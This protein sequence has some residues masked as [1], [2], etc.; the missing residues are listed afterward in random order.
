M[1]R[2]GVRENNCVLIERARKIFRQIW[3]GRHHTKYMLID[4]FGLCDRFLMPPEILNC[5]NK[6]ESFSR[7]GRIDAHQ[8]LD[9]ILE[10]YNRN[11]KNHISGVANSIKWETVTKNYDTL[12]ILTGNINSLLG[13]IEHTR[14]PRQIQEFKSER[15]IFRAELRKTK[16]L[17]PINERNIIGKTKPCIL[18][19]LDPFPDKILVV[20]SE[21]LCQNEIVKYAMECVLLF[22]INIYGNASK[23]FDHVITF[24]TTGSISKENDLFPLLKTSIIYNNS[25]ASINDLVSKIRLKIMPFCNILAK[26]GITGTLSL[27][28]LSFKH[29]ESQIFGLIISTGKL[30]L[31]I[32]L[33]EY[34]RYRQKHQ[35]HKTVD[36]LGQKHVLRSPNTKVLIIMDNNSNRFKEAVSDISDICSSLICFTSKPVYL[37]CSVAGKYGSAEENCLRDIYPNAWYGCTRKK[38]IDIAQPRFEKYSSVRERKNSFP[39]DWIKNDQDQVKKLAKAGFFYPGVGLNGQCYSC[40]G[41]L[42]NVKYH[43]NPLTKHASQYPE[44]KF[45]KETLSEEEIQNAILQFND[46]HKNQILHLNL[47]KRIAL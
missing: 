10:E 12:E 4:S 31:Q 24:I 9:F 1:F 36:V 40:S 35:D 38:V 26:N 42:T 43:T 25:A 6:H 21:E 47:K 41:W 15:D 23:V 19:T 44:C 14:Q 46:A 34:C 29:L 3:Y 22:A 45:I 18:K 13:R 7:S 32:D 5:L 8:G 37:V 11:I 2:K 33:D 17:Y 27:H 30:C 39:T 16:Y 20:I 28:G